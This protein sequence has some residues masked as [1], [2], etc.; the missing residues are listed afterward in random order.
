MA[1]KRRDMIAGEMQKV[2]S[3]IIAEEVKDPS[4]P[5]MCSVMGVEVAADMSFAKVRVSVLGD[6]Q[7]LQQA[8]DALNRA[9]GFIRKQLGMRIDLRYTPKLSFV[10]DQSVQHS[11]E[12]QKVLE[13][14]HQDE[15]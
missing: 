11:I 14:I 4:V 1:N 9:S 5:L 10:G 7:A 6:E 8:V 13:K 12:I 3:A 2:L 15:Q